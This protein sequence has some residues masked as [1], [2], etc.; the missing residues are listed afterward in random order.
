MVGPIN[1]FNARLDDYS[2]CPV[3]YELSLLIFPKPDLHSSPS[4]VL[5]VLYLWLIY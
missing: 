3:N 4:V 5:C 1:R 2:E